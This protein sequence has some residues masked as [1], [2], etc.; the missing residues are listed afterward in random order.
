MILNF[1]VASITII[2]LKVGFFDGYEVGL[3]VVG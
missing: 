2:G 1:F 3:L